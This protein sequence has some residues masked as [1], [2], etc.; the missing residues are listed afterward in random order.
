MR[1]KYIAIYTYKSDD[2]SSIPVFLQGLVVKFLQSI[3]KFMHN[4]NENSTIKIYYIVKS[5]F[6]RSVFRNFP[7]I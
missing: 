2:I 3:L 6:M 1:E 7:I 5:K 4:L